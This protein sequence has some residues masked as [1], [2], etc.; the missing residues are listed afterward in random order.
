MLC[1]PAVKWS[2]HGPDIFWGKIGKMI[3]GVVSNWHV[4]DFQPIDC[5]SFPVLSD[6]AL[7]NVSND[8]YYAYQICWLII[9]EASDPDLQLLEVGPLCHSRWLT[10]GGRILRYYV[11]QDKPS[12]TLVLLTELCIKVYFPKF[13]E[14]KAKNSIAD[15][16]R[17]LFS[18][19]RRVTRFSDK[20][21]RDIALT[22]CGVMPFLLI[23]S[24]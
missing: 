18:K 17:N 9:H 19:L 5:E 14:V 13:F 21:V 20:Q 8:Q 2:S 6:E 10:I 22:L 11:S 1:F 24:M 3:G 12:L 16:P 23:L 7:W 4:K 15:G